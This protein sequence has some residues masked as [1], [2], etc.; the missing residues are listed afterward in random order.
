METKDQM[1]TR[2]TRVIQFREGSQPEGYLIA[3]KIMTKSHLYTQ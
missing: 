3:F 1:E 2:E